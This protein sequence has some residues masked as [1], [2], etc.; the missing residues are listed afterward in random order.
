GCVGKCIYCPV[1]LVDDKTPKS[2]TGKEPSTMRSIMFN[3]NPY[4][5]VENRLHQ[6]DEINKPASKIEIIFQGGTF[7]AESFAHQKYFVKRCIDAVVGKDSKN[8]EEAKL[9]AESSEKRIVGITFETRPDQCS[10]L[11]INRML[12]LG[13]TRVEMGVQI[14]SDEVY[15]KIARGHSVKDVVQATQRLKD[16]AFKV[17]Y[18]LMPGLYGSSP[19]HDIE[20]LSEV[21]SNQDFMPDMVK[22]YPCLVIEKTPLHE[23]WKQ[24]KFS[25]YNTEQASEVISEIKKVIPKWVRIMRIQRDIP[26]DVIAAGVKNSN[27]REFV[28]RKMLE[29]GI[30]CNCIRCREAGLKSHKLK[31]QIDF[32]KVKLLR[33]DYDASNGKEIFLSFE[34]SEFDAL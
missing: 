11:Q 29:K 12:N 14:P 21:F 22:I 3:Y 32:S 7:P 2:Y 9:S 24:G 15:K 34:E 10:K 1:S 13:V 23:L 20:K 33:E 16:S 18:H 19:E 4:K 30:K 28:E 5:I 17:C 25:P 6:Y 26:A 8:I 31:K 27:L